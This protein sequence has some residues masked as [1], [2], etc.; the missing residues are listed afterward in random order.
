[1]SDK[2]TLQ[3]ENFRSIRGAT[4]E[5]APLTVIYGANGSGKSSLIYG[6]LTL[7]S[8]FTNPAQNVPSLFSYPTISLGGLREVVYNHAEDTP[9]SLTL[10]IG[11]E[12]WSTAVWLSV[13][14]SGG[15]VGVEFDYSRAY[16]PTVEMS[17]DIPFPYRGDQQTNGIDHV[18]WFAPDGEP[19]ESPIQLAWNGINV[20]IERNG[21]GIDTAT[22]EN[23]LTYANSPIEL[24]RGTGFAPL[25]RGF[26]TPVYGVTNVT[27][28]LGTDS[29]VASLLATDRYLEYAVSN[30]LETIANRQLRV[31]MQV[32]TS[33][34]NLDSVPRDG[35]TP[36][37]I[38]NEGFGINQLVH[39]LTVCLHSKTK[40]V[41]IEEPEIHLHPSMV[42]KLV[43]ALVDIATE[44]DKRIVVSTHSE[45]FVL[46][47]LAQIADGRIGVDDVSFIFAEKEDG[48][49]RFTK[50]E[51]TPD[52]QIEGGLRS[53]IE[54]ELE[55]MA[56]LFGQSSQAG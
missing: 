9:V 28:S 40:I 7:R 48:E 38:V 20:G 14:E 2:Y 25:K 27:P 23:Y 36:V 8:F 5:I 56:V 55:D 4:V 32:G 1:M 52:G 6:L 37:A 30:Y 18:V 39:M 10:G 43:H 45:T 26:A 11:N 33:S 13:G 35:G 31:R 34:F 42:R 49:S 54:A 3:L 21:Q 46:S 15:A 41:A 53:F 29:E 24:A 16:E 12:N 50:Q 19:V 51:A 47:L 44:H 17:L 22:V